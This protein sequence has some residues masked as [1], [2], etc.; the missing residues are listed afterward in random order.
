MPLLM[1]S[2]FFFSRNGRGRV[3]WL[4]LT[5]AC[6][7]HGIC[8]KPRPLH[9]EES[10]PRSARVEVPDKL[11]PHPRLFL[12]PAE[13]R[14]LK[15]WIARE[16]WLREYVDAFVANMRD[17]IGKV[18]TIPPIVIDRENRKVSRLANELALAYVLTDEPKFAQAAAKILLAYVPIYQQ[19]PV[20]KTKGK[21]MPSTLN[22]ARW[23]GDYA[24]AYDLIYNSGA[25]TD[26]DKQAI[27]TR[28]LKPCGEVLRICNHKRRSN[29]RAR[30]IAGVGVIGFCIDDRDLIEE[31]LHGYRDAQGTVVRNGFVHHVSFSILADGI[32]YERSFGYQ[33]FTADSYFLLLEAARHSGVDLWNHQVPG[34]PLDAGAD[35]E[36]VYGKSNWKSVKP[37]FDA[38]FYRTFSDGTVSVV[39]NASADHFLSRRYYDAAWRAY[40]DPKFAFA[41]RIPPSNKRPWAD[42]QP[43]DRTRLRTATDLMWLE[44]DLPAGH[45]DLA[46]DTRIGQTGI[47]KNG[48][49]LMPNGGFAVLRQNTEPGSL[50]VSMNFGCWGSGHSHP[51]KLSIV[52]SDGHRKAIRE[53]NYFGYQAAQYLT[54]DRQTIAHNTVTV[55]ETSQQ[56][57]GSRLDAWPVPPPGE[58]VRGRPLLF[59]PGDQLKVFRAECTDAYPGVRMERTVV[60]V[61]SILLDFFHCQSD[62]EH[63][64]DYAMHIEGR[65]QTQGEPDPQPVS[66][67]LG[68]R[69]ITDL[70]HATAPL[71]L[72]FDPQGEIDL[73]TPATVTTGMGIQ[74]EQ[75]EQ[76]PV[77]IARQRGKQA[78][79]VSAIRFGPQREGTLVRSESVAGAQRITLPSGL[80]VTN[81]PHRVTLKTAAGKILEVADSQSPATP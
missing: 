50:G 13:I 73:L 57:Q 48:C 33:A 46:V 10:I 14:R 31:A 35:V 45:F 44:P 26:I 51:D 55:D 12:N 23:A 58:I 81:S 5:L 34:H 11:P 16:P 66:E 77:L 80:V 62:R 40:R 15:A 49:T 79:F 7:D 1:N 6:A 2:V 69:H 32:F 43:Q 25:L 22:E 37:I 27:E 65:L 75:G 18:P 20:S 56:P 53:V 78:T 24:S 21:A 47:H 64:Y 36:R 61:D 3:L 9:D 60:L 52:V 4:L 28:V 19:Y 72:R 30:A 63:T 74:G 39:A 68:Y 59:Y 29:W 67:S 71:K 38:L 76:R 54:W 17:S 70:H 42:P 8:D 41:A